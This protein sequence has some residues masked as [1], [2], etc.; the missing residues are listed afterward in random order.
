M[1]LCDQHLWTLI[2]WRWGFI[3]DKPSFLKVSC[4]ISRFSALVGCDCRPTAHSDRQDGVLEPDRKAGQDSISQSSEPKTGTLLVTNPK[5]RRILELTARHRQLPSSRASSRLSR[6]KTHQQHRPL[7]SPPSSASSRTRLSSSPP[8]TS[9]MLSPP[10]SPS[11]SSGPS[12]PRSSP[13]SPPSSH[14]PMPTP[15]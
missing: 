11:P 14:S 5:F 1:H 9:S 10:M 2:V 8:Y 12:S 7:I 6:S 15:R 4:G 13:S 3:A